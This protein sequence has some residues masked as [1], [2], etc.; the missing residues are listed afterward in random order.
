MQG[1]L[2]DLVGARSQEDEQA[3]IG[4]VWQGETRMRIQVRLKGK[5]A[6]HLM[7][8]INGDD[9]NSAGKSFEVS[10]DNGIS[11]GGNGDVGEDKGN[12]RVS[13]DTDGMF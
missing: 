6:G 8:V 12:G 1:H 10:S 5:V 9:K 3:R 11:R 2:G 13:N 4:R 7:H